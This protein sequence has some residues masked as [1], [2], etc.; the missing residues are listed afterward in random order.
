[1]T[2]NGLEQEPEQEETVNKEEAPPDTVCAF[3]CLHATE[4]IPFS[5]SL[6][7]SGSPLVQ[8]VLGPFYRANGEPFLLCPVCDKD[9]PEAI[10]AAETKQGG[11]MCTTKWLHGKQLNSN[12]FQ[13]K[14][15]AGLS[16]HCLVDSPYGP[17]VANDSVRFFV[18]R[19]SAMLLFEGSEEHRR[20]QLPS[21]FVEAVFNMWPSEKRTGF[22]SKPDAKA[23]KRQRKH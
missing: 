11:V 2:E 22:K 6:T 14:L 23:S 13:P 19:V 9:S 1:M 4:C 5:L 17:K 21:C 15:P 20:T 8:F 18:Y 10:E 16:C 3:L 7:L 12:G